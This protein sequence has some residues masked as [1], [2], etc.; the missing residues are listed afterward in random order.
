MP[1]FDIT[2]ESPKSELGNAVELANREIKNR[3]D[4][5]GSDSRVTS[6]GSS[7]TMYADDE[8]KLGQVYSVL[9]T[10]LAKR[11]VD[12]RFLQRGKPEK[13]SGDKLKEEI[14]IRNGI[15]KELGKKLIRL[16]KD[17]KLKVKAT[18]QGASVRVAGQKKDVLQQAMKLAEELKDQ[19]LQF[20][21][22]RD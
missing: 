2:S 10:K 9:T 3:F 16:F 21:N 13:I 4:F 14:I 20:G 12:L 1:S 18:I 11:S 19:P 8:F 7:I 22:F 5:K 17:N 6:D 15:E